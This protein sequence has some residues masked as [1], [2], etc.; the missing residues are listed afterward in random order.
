DRT[1]AGDRRPAA[2]STRAQRG[3]GPASLRDRAARIRFPRRA[4][5]DRQRRRRA[6]PRDGARVDRLLRAAA[7]AR[8]LVSARHR[9][10]R[11]RARGR[12]H[13]L[14]LQ[15]HGKD[16]AHALRRPDPVRRPAG[17]RLERHIACRVPA[18]PGWQDRRLDARRASPAP[19]RRSL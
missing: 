11:A 15:R 12:P 16:G 14:R 4:R 7:R 10:Q 9:R 13:R 18:A 8:L 3:H 6:C 1:L 5:R 17:A 19:P 2:R